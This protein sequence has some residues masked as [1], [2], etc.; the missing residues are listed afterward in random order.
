MV[1]VNPQRGT[2][3]VAERE[4]VLRVGQGFS[5]SEGLVQRHW[6]RSTVRSKGS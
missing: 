3:G 5:S 6:D 4:E 1:V 2:E